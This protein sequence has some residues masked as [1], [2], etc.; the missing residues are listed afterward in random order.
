LV[1]LIHCIEYFRPLRH[2]FVRQIQAIHSKTEIPEMIRIIPFIVLS[3]RRF[4]PIFR[5]NIILCRWTNSSTSRRQSWT[6]SLSGRYLASTQSPDCRR[7]APL[8]GEAKYPAG[9]RPSKCIII[10]MLPDAEASRPSRITWLPR[11][12]WIHAV[13]RLGGDPVVWCATGSGESPGSI[14]A[15]SSFIRNLTRAGC[16][17]GPR[18]EP[19][20]RRRRRCIEHV[21]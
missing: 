7:Y 15:G 3:N 17:R 13:P 12:D 19:R 9:A 2:F 14:P 1:I 6:N 5:K 16:V 21:Y 20:V 10:V 11:Y 18:A 4:D 8:S